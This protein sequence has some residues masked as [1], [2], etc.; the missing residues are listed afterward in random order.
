MHIN[1]EISNF[2]E[3]EV[4]DY[5]GYANL[6]N[7]EAALVQFGGNIV[8]GYKVGISIGIVLPDS[9]V[10]HLPDRNDPNVSCEYKY[11]CY[12]VINDRLN[13]IASKLSS[14]LNRKNYR[15]LPIVV[16]ETTNE[17]EAMPTISHKM[18][19]HIAGL[20]WIGKSCLLVTPQHGP[21]VRFI[22]VLTNAPLEGTDN[23]LEQRCN[24][25]MECMKICPS[26]AIKG[27]NYE[28]QK[29]REE[30]L[31]ISKCREY[32]NSMKKD[33]KW[34]VCGM[35]LYICPYGRK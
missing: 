15:T 13:L 31:D 24:N 25:C 30:R 32:F 27:I 28:V 11:H 20:G 34:D 17:E 16:A 21:R 1:E 29:S 2:L 18:I 33:R 14:Y 3:N 5:I 10:D 35:C 8:K 6:D 12:D 4:V 19:A 9:I 23:P 7:Y 22:T 26:Q